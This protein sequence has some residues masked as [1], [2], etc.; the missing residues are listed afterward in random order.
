GWMIFVIHHHKKNAEAEGADNLSGTSDFGAAPDVIWTW[1][2]PADS[3]KPGELSLEGRIPPIEPQK[4][5]LTPKECTWLGSAQ[6]A[7]AEAEEKR[8]LQALGTTRLIAKELV[9]RTGIPYGTIMK[10]LSSLEEKGNV[11]HQVRKGSGSPKE[12]F[13]TIL[14]TE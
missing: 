12:W 9:E 10:R 6:E 7:S 11:S 13:R 14:E 5:M 3:S 1:K 4:V 2:R 8:I